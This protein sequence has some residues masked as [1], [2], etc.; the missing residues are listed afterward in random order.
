MES[1]FAPL[2]EF[3]RMLMIGSEYSDPSLKTSPLISSFTP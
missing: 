1:S 3:T 2:A